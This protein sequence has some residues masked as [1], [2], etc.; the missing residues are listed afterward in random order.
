MLQI[1][2]GKFF[3]SNE[4]II[5][6][7]KGIL[8]SNY[9]W[10]NHIETC[11]ATLEPVDTYASVCSYVVSYVNQIEKEKPPHK[12]V[13]IRIGDSEIVEQFMLICSFSLNAFFH[14]ERNIV[15][16]A[17]RDQRLSS[18]DYYI[19]S[20]FVPR[21]FSRQLNG[22]S[23]E[24]EQFKNFVKSVIDL[25]RDTYNSIMNSLRSFY[26]ALQVLGN[27]IDLA[28]SLLIYTLEALAQRTDEYNAVWEDY[29]PEVKDDIDKILVSLDGNVASNIREILLK[30]SNIKSLTRFLNF[31]HNNINDQFFISEAPEGFHTVRKSEFDRAL[32][33][34]YKLRSKFAH[35]LQP[36]QALL[37][38]P[39]TAN[40]D[41][42]RF[43]NEIYLSI[44]GLVRVAR[45][46]I[47]NFVEKQDKV[48][49]EKYDWRSNLP[50]I[51]QIELAPQYWIWKHEGFK[52]QHITKILSG[53]LSQLE[54]VIM[55]S[56]PLTDI[57]ELLNKFEP[58][59]GQASYVHQLQM[60]TMYILYNSLVADENKCKNH[61]RFID[62]YKNVLEQCTIESMITFLILG[63]P[64]MWSAEIC[65]KCWIEYNRTIHRKAN[66]NI[67]Q[68]ICIA[69]M[70][71][72][73]SL[74]LSEKN[75]TKYKEWMQNALL[76]ASG[77]NKLQ[78]K[79]I[80]SQCEFIHL[81]GY[82]VINFSKSN[83]A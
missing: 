70:V 79:L 74:F 25:K 17:C 80:K 54:S 31:V 29:P 7:G 56:A 76:E 58:L 1:I 32:R 18:S 50:G 38:H 11:V 2:S 23:E 27:N 60:L 66:I 33:N 75:E 44:A 39:Q 67:P 28:Y 68:I 72:V 51:L 46:V 20:Q 13:L 48:T 64:M 12:N 9:S 71:E 47:K 69:L 81:K 41:V 10:I 14:Q 16:I 37:K 45:H 34:A 49:F 24:V 53:F 22:K 52:T 61:I 73:A 82:D 36:I 62:K 63:Q 5:H 26:N 77:K 35:T 55:N 4:R 83:K 30:N 42:I 65:A 3:E 6:N 15:S 40:G 43:S 19:P 59:M 8:F 78:N 57:R 21:I